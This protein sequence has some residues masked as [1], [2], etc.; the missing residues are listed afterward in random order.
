MLWHP[1]Q[2]CSEELLVRTTLLLKTISESDRIELLG[3]LVELAVLGVDVVG[4]ILSGSVLK[5]FLEDVSELIHHI[6]LVADL[7]YEVVE[8][9]IASGL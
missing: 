6:S 4:D 9:N 7:L 8:R 2:L 1:S 3:V 5:V